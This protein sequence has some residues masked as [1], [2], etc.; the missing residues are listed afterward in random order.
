MDPDQASLS[1]LHQPRQRKQGGPT[2]R[3]W[4]HGGALTSKSPSCFI[5]VHCLSLVSLALAVPSLT[6]NCRSV[7]LFR[8]AWKGGRRMK[9]QGG[10]ER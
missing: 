5:P 4:R 6:K 1:L 8:F 9:G 3:P 2:I 7:P 10:D